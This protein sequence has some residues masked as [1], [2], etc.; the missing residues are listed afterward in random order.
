M[1]VALG[2]LA[3][4]CLLLLVG[5]AGKRAP[6]DLPAL[7]GDVEEGVAS[8]YGTKYHGRA[9]ASGERYDMYALTAAH[10]TL[11]FGVLVEVTNLQNDRRVRVRINDRGPFKEGR[12]IDLSYA[13]A[14][15][16]GMVRQGLAR[17]SVRVVGTDPAP[18]KGR[19]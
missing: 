7:T 4:A 13:A 11:P 19:R 14:R 8:W 18:G 9:T 6:A 5:C 15:K 3:A 10:P 12:I 16:L 1:R 17:V 2:F